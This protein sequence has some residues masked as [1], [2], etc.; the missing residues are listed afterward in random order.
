MGIIIGK[1]NPV[2]VESE[3]KSNGME[4]VVAATETKAEPVESVEE[5]VQEKPKV[6]ETPKAKRQAR[7]KRR[8]RYGETGEKS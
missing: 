7:P 3:I 6:E 2:K 8:N 5:P 4:T 1:D